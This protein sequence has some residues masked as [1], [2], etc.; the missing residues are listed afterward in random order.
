MHYY[1]C[2]D[3]RMV[4]IS[5]KYLKSTADGPISLKHVSNHIYNACITQIYLV[6]LLNGMM[7]RVLL[8]YFYS[9]YVF[10]Q[11]ITIVSADEDLISFA[12]LNTIQT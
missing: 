10:Q 12:K 5:F 2:L 7:F 8:I 1:F 9:I 6:N 4:P 3:F 11:L